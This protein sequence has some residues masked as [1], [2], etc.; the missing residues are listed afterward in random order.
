MSNYEETSGGSISRSLSSRER[1]LLR[2]LAENYYGLFLVKVIEGIIHNLNGPMQIL[3][4]RS[5]QLEQGLKQ[6]GGALGS[7][8]ITEAETLTDRMEEK[9]K[10]ISKSLDDL[11]A[12]FIRLRNDLSTERHS[13]TGDVKINQ[14]I[15][16]SLLLLNADMFFKHSVKKTFS[17]ADGLPVLNGRKTDFSIIILSLIQNA[18]EAMAD[19]EVKN[20]SVETSSRDGNVIV[21]IEDT[22]CGISEQDVE[23]IY[24]VFFTTKKGQGNENR[25][26]IGLSLVALLLEDY[27]GSIKCKTVPGKTSFVIEIPSPAL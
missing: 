10:S 26:G 3:Y 24:D 8:D 2:R 20:L 6:L 11:N 17:L 15:E 27:N 18:V 25:Q 16:D 13:E 12:Q 1:L 19:A 7:E 22:G 4:I 5:E 21:K 9:I 23:R 14:V